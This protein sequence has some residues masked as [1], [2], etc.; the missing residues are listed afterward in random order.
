MTETPPVEILLERRRLRRAL[1]FW[2]LLALGLAI[3]A[4]VALAARFGAMSSKLSPHIA[5]I[6]LKGL[7]TGDRDTIKLIDEL[8]ESHARAVIVSISSPGGTVSGSQRLYDALRRLD[9]KKPVV[10]VVDGLAASGAYIAA[11]GAERIFADDNALVGSIGV[12]FQYPNVYKLLETLG[13][14]VETIKSS[15]LKASPN[16]FEPT[17]PAARA[18][19]DALVVDSYG[20]FKNLVKD[21]RHMS[22][23]ELAAVDDGRVF[24]GHMA[25]PLKLVDEAG[26]ERDA[27]RWLEKERNLPTDLPVRDWKKDVGGGRFDLFGAAAVA[28]DAAGWPDAGQWLAR[29]AQNRDSVAL[30]GLLAIWQVRGQ[31]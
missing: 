7:I 18:A 21:R 23:E 31:D 27:I 12:L 25:L 16:G 5:R 3:L 20:W 14:Q 9:G 6:E 29:I 28:L 30:D 10:A 15:P 17:S 26:G 1:S 19:I 13:V 24:T 8:G 11:L 4:V 22:A 2:R